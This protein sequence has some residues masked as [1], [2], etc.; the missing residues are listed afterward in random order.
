MTEDFRHNEAVSFNGSN[1]GA[2]WWSGHLD[3]RLPLDKPSAVG[4]NG[5]SFSLYGPNMP[6]ECVQIKAR[7]GHYHFSLPLF[8]PIVFP[9]VALEE[10]V[11]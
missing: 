5:F 8:V 10:A 7:L 6:W 2:G 1:R 4:R 9:L 3:P 11:L